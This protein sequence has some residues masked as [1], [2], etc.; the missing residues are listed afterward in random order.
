[1]SFRDYPLEAD[2]QSAL[3]RLDSKVYYWIS[4]TILPICGNMY[5]VMTETQTHFTHINSQRAR[6]EIRSLGQHHEQPETYIPPT[7]KL[8][9][10][11]THLDQ[12]RKEQNK[13]NFIRD[14]IAIGA[15]AL[16]FVG[17][18]ALKHKYDAAHY[19]TV[20]YQLQPGDRTLWQAVTH[21]EHGQEDPRPEVDRITEELG[22]TDISGVD[23]ID[24][25]V[26]R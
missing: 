26:T 6:R 8:E 21:A 14:S 24:V 15:V 17:G 18:A 16:V 5:S 10:G 3:G 19:K 7:L 23:A 20:H 22:T 11:A 25:H 12:R 4:L 1:V 13:R 2:N 9:E